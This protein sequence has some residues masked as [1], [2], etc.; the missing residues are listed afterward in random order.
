M[1]CVI[2]PTMH[3]V[4]ENIVIVE[5]ANKGYE[6]MLALIF[7]PARER[8]HSQLS[9]LCDNEPG[10]SSNTRRGDEKMVHIGFR[11]CENPQRSGGNPT[12]FKVINENSV[13][14]ASKFAGQVFSILKKRMPGIVERFR[15][16]NQIPSLYLHR[17]AP[18]HRYENKCTRHTQLYEL[19]L[20]YQLPH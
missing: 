8:L 10:I 20:T 9:T 1:F 12:L 3:R 13:P 6:V 5:E 2:T 7:E 19:I 4:L 18:V 11:C 17:D 16:L 14:Q 15:A